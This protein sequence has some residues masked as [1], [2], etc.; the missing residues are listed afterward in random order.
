MPS[1]VRIRDMNLMA[2]ITECENPPQPRAPKRVYT[3]NIVCLANS[4]KRGGRCIAGKEILDGGF[5]AWIRPASDRPNQ[6]LSRPECSLWGFRRPELLDIVSVPL[7]KPVP[8]ATR[9][10]TI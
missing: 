1:A 8:T 6:E 2:T 7:L 9:L 10:R 4:Y 5:G 3:K